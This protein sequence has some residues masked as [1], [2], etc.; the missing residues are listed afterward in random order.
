MNEI[1]ELRSDQASQ[2]CALHSGI[3]PP[4]P[5]LPLH[6]SEELGGRGR[7]R[8]HQGRVMGF[9]EGQVVSRRRENHKT[10][11]TNLLGGKKGKES[12]GWKPKGRMLSRQG[13]LETLVRKQHW[14]LRL[15]KFL[16]RAD[17][18]KQSNSTV[19]QTTTCSGRIL[20]EFRSGEWPFQC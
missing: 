10:E 13:V 2:L 17:S 9:G 5:G 16:R 1:A 4:E 12:H 11:N 7:S 6:W 18:N 19:T 14:H 8:R 15:H 3:Y 20:P